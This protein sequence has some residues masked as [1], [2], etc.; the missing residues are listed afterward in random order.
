MPTWAPLGT[1]P[2]AGRSTLPPLG[3]AGPEGWLSSFSSVVAGRGAPGPGPGALS[4]WVPSTALARSLAQEA[5]PEKKS[6]PRPHCRASPLPPPDPPPFPATHLLLLVS[7]TTGQCCIDSLPS[8]YTRGR[9]PSAGACINTEGAHTP[10]SEML[11]DTQCGHPGRGSAATSFLSFSSRPRLRHPT[12][13]VSGTF[14]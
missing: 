3:Q 2:G 8:A 10:P 1:K 5:V 14:P 4:S 13:T 6:A 11:G 9:P 7:M 12:D